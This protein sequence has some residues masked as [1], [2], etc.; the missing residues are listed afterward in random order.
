[1]L[2]RCFAI[3]VVGWLI[4]EAV[5]VILKGGFYRWGLDYN[6]V[7]FQAPDS[8]ERLVFLQFL[9]FGFL[10]SG[11]ASSPAWLLLVTGG[12]AWCAHAYQLPTGDFF[13]TLMFDADD[14]S[15]EAAVGV[16]MGF[17]FLLTWLSIHYGKIRRQKQ[18]NKQKEK[19]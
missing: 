8:A 3:E 19:E 2:F 13:P 14:G 6:L 10:A 4:L 7:Y 16:V 12:V 5:V 9:V 11:L 15:S 18:K 17:V 1:M